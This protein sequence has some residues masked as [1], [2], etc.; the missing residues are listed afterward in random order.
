VTGKGLKVG[1][2]IIGAV[3]LFLLCVCGGLAIW[4][5]AVYGIGDL[6]PEPV[7][8]PTSSPDG[9]AGPSAEPEPTDESSGGNTTFVSGDCLVNDGTDDSP[10]LR[11]VTCG[12]NTYEVLVRIPF[13]TDVE[14]CNERAPDHDANYVH[15]NSLDVA[16]YVLCLKMR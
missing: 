9:S 5:V 15:D 3:V 11:K 2:I 8:A 7:A 12:P 16:D 13:T 6:D 14:E 1:L 10:D 4:A